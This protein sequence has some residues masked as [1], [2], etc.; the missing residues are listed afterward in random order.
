[1]PPGVFEQVPTDDLGFRAR[2]V[3]SVEVLPVVATG[4]LVP[5]LLDVGDAP[6]L[7][8]IGEISPDLG[9]VAEMRLHIG[10]DNHAVRYTSPSLTSTW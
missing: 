7:V 8:R 3:L 10:I 6:Q 5:L 2:V 9:V 4:R 1:M